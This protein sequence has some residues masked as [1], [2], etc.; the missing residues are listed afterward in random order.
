MILIMFC[1]YLIALAYISKKIIQTID[2]IPE[3]IRENQ[4]YIKEEYE[5]ED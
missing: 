3:I 5:K 4:R 2:S 1:I